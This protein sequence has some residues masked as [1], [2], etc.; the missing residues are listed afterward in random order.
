MNTIFK[1]LATMVHEQGEMVDSIEVHVSEAQVRV[2]EG[3]QQL[4]QAEE[5][6]VLCN[7]QE[8]FHGACNKG[9]DPKSEF[10]LIYFIFHCILFQS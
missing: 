8:A 9:L 1:D 2:G 6:K 4:R 5:Y 10:Y 7:N 3:T